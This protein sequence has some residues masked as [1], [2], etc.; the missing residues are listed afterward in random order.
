[1]SEVLEETVK[2]SR[3]SFGLTPGIEPGAFCLWDGSDSDDVL[4]WKKEMVI[5]FKTT[6]VYRMRD[7][8]L[9]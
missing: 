8:F 4:G 9:K 1:M 2:P 6:F 7:S 5:S 3:A